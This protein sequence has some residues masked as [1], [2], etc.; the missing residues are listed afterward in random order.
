MEFLDTLIL[1]ESEF[2]A[3]ACMQ[4]GFSAVGLCGISMYAKDNFPALK[5]LIEDKKIAKVYIVW[6]NDDKVSPESPRFKEKASARYDVEYYAYCLARKLDQIEG[7]DCYIGTL[8]DEWRVDGKADIDGALAQGVTA[9]QFERVLMNAKNCW[10]YREDWKN[11]CEEICAPRIKRF[12]FY[13]SVMIRE[14]K[15]FRMKGESYREISNFT[16]SIVSNLLKSPEDLTRLLVITDENG[17][18]SKPIDAIPGVF[19]SIQQFKEWLISHGNYYFRGNQQDLDEIYRRLCEFNDNKITENPMIEGFY[20]EKYMFANVLISNTSIV[21]PDEHGVIWHEGIGYKPAPFNSNR[22]KAD[23]SLHTDKFDYQ[24]A[25]KRLLENWNCFEPA[26][27]LGWTIATIFSDVIWEQYNLFPIMFVGG[28]K[29]GGKTTLCEFLTAFCG[30]SK[31]VS[32]AESTTAA[33]LMLA[34]GYYSN[35]PVWLD[36][37]R[38][39]KVTFDRNSIFRSIYN[40]QGAIKG[41]RNVLG[42]VRID[43]IRGTLIMSGEVSPDDSALLTRCIHIALS[44]KTIRGNQ[45]KWLVQNKELFGYAYLDIARQRGRVTELMKEIDETKNLLIRDYNLSE[46]F[47]INYAIT[48]ASLRMFTNGLITKESEVYKWCCLHSSGE[49]LAA[50]EEHILNNFLFDL[51]VLKRKKDLSEDAVHISFNSDGNPSIYVHVKV[52][53]DSYLK[54]QKEIGAPR[55]EWASHR[56]IMTYMKNSTWK[57]TTRRTKDART[58]RVLMTEIKNL[59]STEIVEN[60]MKESE[61]ENVMELLKISRDNPGREIG[62]EG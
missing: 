24:D 60:F 22:H 5:K 43:P 3:V 42:Q 39:S 57:E 50:N 26:L 21:L 56:T 47:A 8:P 28:I 14:R 40:R 19:T 58:L 12:F 16:L 11:E 32:N 48:V 18:S 9:Q 23:I 15:Y 59:P 7:T 6:D 2:K 1:A 30:T 49:Q 10:K 46:R 34:M 4:Y 29:E 33:G 25:F 55:R 54:Y 31:M 61:C 17:S 35:L 13:S 37:Y 51:S 62:E 20:N 27:G 44:D 53:F 38:T 52:A 41:I 45:Y 36:E